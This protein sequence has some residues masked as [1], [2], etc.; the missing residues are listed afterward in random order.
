V[1]DQLLL[2]ESFGCLEVVDIKN[3][4]ITSTHDFKDG[5]NSISDLL[6]IDDSHYLVASD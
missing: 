6:A 5:G 2:G 1:G 3:F 4:N